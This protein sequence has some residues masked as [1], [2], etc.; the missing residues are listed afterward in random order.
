[1]RIRSSQISISKNSDKREAPGRK[2]ARASSQA[3]A[4]K[5]SASFQVLSH[6]GQPL[7]ELLQLCLESEQ[8][9]LWAEFVSRSHPII[10]GVIIKTIRRWTRPDPSLIDDLV[11]E[12]YLKL[13]LNNFRALR[14]F[15]SQH[16]NSVFGFLKVVASNTVR[17]HF[18]AVYSQK[19][20]SGM[21]LIPLDCVPL[22][23]LKDASPIAE[24]RIRLQT[25]DDCLN[26]YVDGPNSSRD[27]MIF[28]LYY[29]EGLTAK[30]IS[31][32]PSI[33]LG[34]KG[35]E[36]T[37]WRLVRL[38]RAKANFN[39]KAVPANLRNRIYRRNLCREN[40]DSPVNSNNVPQ[41]SRN[42]VNIN[43]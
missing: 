28:W 42:S 40:P 7:N 32:L 26:T 16:E 14:H 4:A 9:A 22:A 6:E 15:D 12:T 27:R 8:E 18:R 43:T 36:N 30:A 2:A 19:R 35:V 41:M 10:A 31:G 17:D 25:V 13:C 33:R 3:P 1:M 24:R 39:C 23:E 5:T 37:I 34:V 11:Q 29:R 20:G 38:L 21:T